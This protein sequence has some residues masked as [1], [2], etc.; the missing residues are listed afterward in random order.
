MDVCNLFCRAKSLV[1]AV[2]I[3]HTKWCEKGTPYRELKARNSQCIFSKEKPVDLTMANTA[4]GK[5]GEVWI[6]QGTKNRKCNQ[7]LQMDLFST[8]AFPLLFVCKSFFL[9]LLRL[10][11]IVVFCWL[12]IFFPLFLQLVFLWRRT[13]PPVLLDSVLELGGHF[14]AG[15]SATG[16]LSK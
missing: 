6:I 8:C 12:I 9:N 10:E 4:G 13:S 1:N 7:E 16:S 15:W 2:K 14:S 5:T 11:R 3:C